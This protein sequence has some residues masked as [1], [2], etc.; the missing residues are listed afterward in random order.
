MRVRVALLSALTATALLLGLTVSP[1]AEA[2]PQRVVALEWE[3]VEDVLA[4]GV[5]PVGA[6]DVSGMRKWTAVPVPRGIEDVGTRQEPSL[7]RIAALKPDLIIAPKFRVSRNLDDLRRIAPTLVLDA[8][9]NTSRRGAQYRS[10]MRSFRRIAQGLRL[11]AR[12]ESV[13]RDLDRTLL[14]LRQ[15][16][17]EERLAGRR[18]TFAV[19]FGTPSGTQARLSTSNSLVAGVLTRLGLRNGWTAP[20]DRFG[21]STVGLEAFRRVQRGWLVL[22]YLP[23]FAPLVRAW[24]REPAWR[25]LEMVRERRVRTVSGDTW[26]YGG[27]LSTKILARRVASQLVSGR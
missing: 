1:S 17:R 8:Y 25:R 23:E 11:R 15:R 18:V 2:A 4:L 12:G 5:T 24:Q 6:A 27:P 26:P 9:P 3:Y 16:L 21:F 20:A 13:L 22:S 10:T 7:E 19:V 14:K